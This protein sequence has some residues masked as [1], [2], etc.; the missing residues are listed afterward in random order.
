MWIDVYVKDAEGVP[1]F[2]QRVTR[3]SDDEGL[4]ELHLTMCKH[5]SDSPMQPLAMDSVQL[6]S[7]PADAPVSQR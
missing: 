2:K 3:P 1:H 5:L 4:H 6:V 7:Y